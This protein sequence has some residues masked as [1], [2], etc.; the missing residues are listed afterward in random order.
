MVKTRSDDAVGKREL[1][2]R[3]PAELRQLLADARAE[4]TVWHVSH[5]SRRELVGD[6]PTRCVCGADYTTRGSGA[7][8]NDWLACSCGGHFWFGCVCGRERVEPPL[9]HD[10]QPK[11]PGR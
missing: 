6:K 9:A 3:T 4:A 1:A 8:P 11:M 7:T 5:T 2:A 10:C